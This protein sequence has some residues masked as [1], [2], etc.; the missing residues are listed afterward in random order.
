MIYS[1][2]RVIEGDRWI[3]LSKAQ[4]G[5]VRVATRY[6]LRQR[7]A[8][9]GRRVA[10]PYEVGIL[11]DEQGR[12]VIV[13]ATAVT[14]PLDE[15]GE[16]AP[17]SLSGFPVIVDDTLPPDVIEVRGLTAVRIRLDAPKE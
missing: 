5:L 10:G 14:V 15:V 12:R 16:V 9:D 8:A 13:V 6:D 11:Y 4:R 1:A 2:S 7:A 3:G 17:R